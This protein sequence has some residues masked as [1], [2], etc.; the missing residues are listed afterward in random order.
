MS[1]LGFL[2]IDF[3]EKLLSEDEALRTNLFG[4]VR[5][6]ASQRT[7]PKEAI[8]DYMTDHLEILSRNTNPKVKSNFEKLS[9]S[10]HK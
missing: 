9:R 3:V 2:N 7:V 5:S 10:L 4:P 6:M 1:K 8:V